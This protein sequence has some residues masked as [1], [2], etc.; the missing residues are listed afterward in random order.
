MQQTYFGQMWAIDISSVE[1]FLERLSPLKEKLSVLLWQ[2]PPKFG[3]D[4]DRLRDFLLT[5]IIKPMPPKM[6]L[7]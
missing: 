6:R 3:M 4:I 2:L 5:T 7:G 1:M